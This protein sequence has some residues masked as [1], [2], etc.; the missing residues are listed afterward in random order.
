MDNVILN[1]ISNSIS[2][3]VIPR[4][5]IAGMKPP[6]M[7]PGCFIHMYSNNMITDSIFSNTSTYSLQNDPWV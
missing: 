3:D 5:E 6:Y 7:C 4:S 1:W 2:A